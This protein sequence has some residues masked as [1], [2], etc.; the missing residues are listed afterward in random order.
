MKIRAYN[1]TYNAYRGKSRWKK[2]LLIALA[3]IAALALLVLLVGWL[4]FRRELSIAGTIEKLDTA[5]PAYYME[6]K[7]DY[8]FEEFLAN[9]G[10]STDGLV[11]GFLS[12]KSPK[13]SIRPR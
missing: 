10:A 12:K 9:G 11:S 7:G 1:K 5:A 2:W 4:I 13:A 8:Y 6:V 3:A